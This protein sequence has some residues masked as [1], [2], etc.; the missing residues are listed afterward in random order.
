MSPT[1]VATEPAVLELACVVNTVRYRYLLI[2]LSTGT[3]KTPESVK[4]FVLINFLWIWNPSASLYITVEGLRPNSQGSV[5]FCN[6]MWC[7]TLHTHIH[8]SLFFKHNLSLHFTK[9]GGGGPHPPKTVMDDDRSCA[10]WSMIIFDNFVYKILK[11]KH[12]VVCGHSDCKA[13]NLLYNLHT[14]PVTIN[15]DLSHGPLRWTLP[16]NFWPYCS[17]SFT[18]SFLL[19]RSGNLNF[20]VRTPIFFIFADIFFANWMWWNPWKRTS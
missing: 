8:S 15:S 10:G 4:S 14:D 5:K 3:F 2:L 1:A 12:V 18:F 19:V 13:V 7:S 9:V 11:V 17:C 16:W 6:H 20:T